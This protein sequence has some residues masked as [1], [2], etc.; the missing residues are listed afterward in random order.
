MSKNL[1]PE[2]NSLRRVLIVDDNVLNTHL[3]EI[4]L[5]RMGWVADV[6]HSGED[7]IKL[8]RDSVYSMVLLDLRMPHMRG[9]DICQYI[10]RELKNHY[11]PVVA[12]TAHGSGEDMG[13]VLAKGFN[14][15]LTKPVSFSEFQSVCLDVTK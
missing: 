3:A 9:E 15:L 14:A 6:T 8:L 5:D 4:F 10:R 2:N 11:L 7:A 1:N 12:Y 13:R